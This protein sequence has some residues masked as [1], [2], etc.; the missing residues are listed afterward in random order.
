VGGN[1]LILSTGVDRSHHRHPAGYRRESRLHRE[2]QNAV[3]GKVTFAGCAITGTVGN[4]SITATDAADSLS[5]TSVTFTLLIN[6]ASKLVLLSQPTGAVDGVTFGSDPVVALEDIGGNIETA[7]SSGTVTLAINTQPGTGTLTCDNKHPDT[8]RGR[9]GLHQLPR[10][11]ARWATTTLKATKIAITPAISTAITI[12]DRRRESTG[13]VDAAGRGRR[14][15]DPQHVA[16]RP[17]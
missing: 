4:Y 11:P 17:D 8:R 10:S 15:T 12:H 5:V 16:G 1:V 13:L 3:A 7:T 2:P 14:R 9:G 6:T